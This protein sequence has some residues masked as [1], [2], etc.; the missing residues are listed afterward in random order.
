MGGVRT[1]VWGETTVPGLYACG[2]CAC[3]AVHGANRLASNSLLEAVVFS[4]RAAGRIAS[5]VDESKP[6]D[7][8]TP[9]PSDLS[10]IE[11]EAVEETRAALKRLMW[12]RLGI[13]RAHSS[14]AAAAS[15][16]A[17]LRKGWA[18]LVSGAAREPDGDPTAWG[19]A[20]ETSNMLE[21]AALIVRCALWRR[22]SRGLHFDSEH[23]HRDNEVFLRDSIL[24]PP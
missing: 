24:S 16:L 22:E 17:E 19:R 23:P 5:D 9:A 20:V 13:V 7:A 1:N 3:V 18:E 21:V 10:G 14:I 4:E 11:S 6:D 12:E 15:Q 8:H 2:E